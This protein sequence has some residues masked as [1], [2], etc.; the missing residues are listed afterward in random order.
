M[1]TPSDMNPTNPAGQPLSRR[2]AREAA[3]RAA[4][5]ALPL[6]EDAPHGGRATEPVAQDRALTDMADLFAAAPV[7]KTDTSARRRKR[8]RGCLGWLIALLVI[9]AMLVAGGIV[10]NNVWGEQIRDKMGWGEPKDYAADQKPGEPTS[11]A[12]AQGDT[13]QAIS[14]TLFDAGVTKTTSAFYTYLVG[15]DTAPEFYP[16]TYEIPTKLSA[17]NALKALQDPA[18]KRENT[19]L[20]RE[21]DTAQSIYKSLATLLKVTPEDVTAAAADPS[22]Y[23]VKAATLEGW[24]FPA[25]YQ[26]DEG[27]TPKQA[28]EKMVA[29]TNQSLADAQVPA[30]QQERVLIIASIIQREAR[31]ESDFYKVSR[32]IQNRLDQGMKLQMDSTAQYGYGEIHAGSVSTSSEAQNDVNDWNTYTM[33][34]LPK[35]PISSPGD[36]AIKAAMA[37]ADGPWLYF[38]TVNLDTGETLF[39]TNYEDHERGVTQWQQWCSAHPDSGC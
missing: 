29:R 31:S 14:A 4:G 1:S 15:L 8:R 22:A 7:Q 30:D 24:L 36:V 12:I 6:H 25:T 23:G 18:N 9:V 13:G 20:I 39:T 11:V 2:E 17:A 37:P 19:L 28:I 38:V 34:G 26:F 35:T 33:E 3:Q 5:P 16:G 21:G 10:V 27:T 32:V